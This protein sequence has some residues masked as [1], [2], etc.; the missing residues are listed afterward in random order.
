MNTAADMSR[1]FAVTT[2]SSSITHIMVWNARSL[3]SLLCL[4]FLL[5]LL[6]G[7]VLRGIYFLPVMLL[8]IQFHP[9][10]CLFVIL[11]NYIDLDDHLCI[12]I[13]ADVKYT[14]VRRQQKH[15]HLRAPVSIAHKL[16]SS[17]Y[18]SGSSI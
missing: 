10:Y 8:S 6:C 5:Y 15:G 9:Q 12:R 11:V 1:L 16:F 7:R 17:Y 13:H 2:I 3:P 4:A 14:G 18:L